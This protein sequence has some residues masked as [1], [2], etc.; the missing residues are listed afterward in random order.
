[1][2]VISPAGLTVIPVTPKTT[3][4][5]LV[6]VAPFLGSTKSTDCAK[7]EWLEKI[8]RALVNNKE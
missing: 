2:A 3:L 5:G 7:A 6:T 1:L 4:N 8:R